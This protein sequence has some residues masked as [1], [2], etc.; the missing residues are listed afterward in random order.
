[1]EAAAAC[2]DFDAALEARPD[3]PE[4]H[5]NRGTVLMRLEGPEAALTAFDRAIALKPVYPD[6]LVGR[7]VA[8]KELRRFDEALASFDQAIAQN[9]ESAHAHNNK[10]ALQ[11][12]QADFENGLAG[13]E[14]RWIVGQTHKFKLEF[15]IPEWSGKI[16]AGEKLIV[17]DEQGIGDTIQFC[18]F[19]SPLAEA[20][21]D[22]TFF[23]RSSAFRLMQSLPQHI[24]CVNTFGPEERFDSEIA[25]SSIPYALGTRLSTIPAPV[26]YLK[27]EKDLAATWAKRL[28]EMGSMADFK[29]GLCWA[30]NP[31]VKADPE[32]SIPLRNFLPLLTLPGV[33]VIAV[34]K[35]HGLEEIAGLPKHARLETLG[36]NFDS[37]SDAFIDTAAVMQ[38]LDLIV[39]CDTSVAHLA[40]A[41]GRPTFVL[42]KNVP[43]WRWMLDRPDTPW[44]PTLRLF[45]QP[46]RGDWESAVAN[47]VEAVEQM[48]SAR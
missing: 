23:C 16:R 48:K 46:E 32:R 34:Q 6:A 24:R 19:L 10:G 29:I 17:F 45:R 9:P 18:R 4:A 8:L 30:G 47:V 33:R 5:F 3:S 2:A 41:L 7:G 26:P 21:L 44:Y 28:A 42:V 12:L 25:L 40:G 15:P 11:L 20:G 43:D 38:S 35:H 37:G 22:I 27:A 13:Y 36:E 1:G 31:N 14:Y 39:S